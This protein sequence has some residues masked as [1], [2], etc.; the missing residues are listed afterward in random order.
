VTVSAE[1]STGTDAAH[2]LAEYRPGAFFFAS[3]RGSVLGTGVQAAATGRR[4]PLE[5]EVAKLLADTGG[6]L[7]IG[8]LPFD[9]AAKPRL[10]VPHTVHRGEGQVPGL[11]RGEAPA[12][13]PN[14]A[15]RA[16][17]EPA[18][19]LQTVRNAL[20]ALEAGDLDKVVLARSLEVTAP[21]LIDTAQAVRNLA[22]RD[23]FG[24]TFAVDLG[25]GVNSAHRTLLGASPELLVHKSGD[26]L[27]SNPM[28]G[29]APRGAD[30][31]EDKRLGEGLLASAKDRREHEVVIEAVADTLAPFCR[32]LSVP[33]DPSLLRTRA[34]W[35][36]GTRIVGTLA[37]PEV[38]SLEL[39]TALHPTPAVCGWPV[40]AAQAS[41]R[42]LEPFDRGFYG[43][44]VGWTDATGD[45]EWAVTLRCG[46]IDGNEV[47][48]YAGGGIVIGSRPEAELDETTVK[49]R[50][51]L[52]AIGIEE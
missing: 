3:P 29:S 47:R 28:A 24:H 32:R 1:S 17:P 41:V 27:V 30:P 43:G 19:H 16:V 39:A 42:A 14:C 15:I 48:L 6:D 12:A 9:P 4:G 31:V 49:F 38:S 13:A 35:H 40:A 33:T 22:G 23:P 18:T 45:G 8:A 46:E 11:M 37:D 50:T 21:D 36:L 2:L 7:V 52:S 26:V 20:T 25:A 34:V 10:V 51:L 44:M 5:L